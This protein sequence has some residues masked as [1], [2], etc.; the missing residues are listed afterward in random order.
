MLFSTIL[1]AGTLLGSVQAWYKP[2]VGTTWQIQYEGTFLDESVVAEA[3]D[4]DGFNATTALITGLHNQYRRAI[5]YFSAGSIEN[6]AP[7][8]ASFPT[9]V[10]GKV[11]DGWPDEKWLDIRQLSIVS[12]SPMLLLQ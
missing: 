2:S 9:S 7:D 10:A 6:Y 1:K 8:F 3:Y 11:L 12:V 4:I 5:C